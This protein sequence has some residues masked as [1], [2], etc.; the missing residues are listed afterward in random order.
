MKPQPRPTRNNLSPRRINAVLWCLIG[1]LLCNRPAGW[2]IWQQRISGELA[3]AIQLLSGVALM[4]ALFVLNRRCAYS[5]TITPCFA[6]V[7]WAC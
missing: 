6:K 4:A 1:F 5:L 7:W 3:W 2:L